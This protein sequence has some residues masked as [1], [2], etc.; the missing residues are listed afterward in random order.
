MAKGMTF[1]AN[2][3]LD[4]LLYCD[5]RADTLRIQIDGASDNVN[6]AMFCVVGCLIKAG[7]FKSV[8]LDR[9]PTG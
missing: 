1:T 5:L 4:I 6:Y 9:L 7:I 2:I 8:F 3:L